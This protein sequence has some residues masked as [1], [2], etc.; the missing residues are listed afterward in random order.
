ME[1]LGKVKVVGA[2]QT[3]E[4]NIQEKRIGCHEQYPSIDCWHEK[5]TKT[6]TTLSRLNN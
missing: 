1:I 3:S 6:L 4:P 5:R 2:E